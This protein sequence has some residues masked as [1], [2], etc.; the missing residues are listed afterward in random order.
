MI[1]KIE[2]VYR[3]VEM[4]LDERG[5]KSTYTSSSF[6]FFP[7]L[8]PAVRYGHQ[9]KSSTYEQLIAF[10]LCT[11]VIIISGSLLAWWMRKLRNSI[12]LIEKLYTRR[13]KQNSC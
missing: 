5:L 2:Y 3:R 1:P 6:C 12:K 7:C 8:H 10:T 4:Y 13:A 11:I 9:R